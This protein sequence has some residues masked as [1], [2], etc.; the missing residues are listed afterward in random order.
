MKHYCRLCDGEGSFD[1][2]CSCHG[3]SVAYDCIRCSNA[4]IVG[5]DCTVCVGT[6]E[7]CS[8]EDV[9][10]SLSVKHGHEEYPKD[11]SH[12]EYLEFK[13]ECRREDRA[14]GYD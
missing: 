5:Q 14:L 12:E 3:R 7:L 9:L 2:D 13:E 4:G 10:Y 1:S 11:T 6:G 8:W